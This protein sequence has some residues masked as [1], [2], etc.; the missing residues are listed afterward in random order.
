MDRGSSSPLLAWTLVPVT[1]A[2]VLSALSLPHQPYT[3]LVLQGD[4][5][6]AVIAGSPAERAGLAPGDRLVPPAGQPGFTRSPL[7]YAAVGEPL[8]ALRERGGRLTAVRV[9]PVRAAGR[10][11]AHDGGPARGGLAASCS[12][13]AGCGASGATGSRA[14]SSC[15]AS[16]SPGCWPRCR[17]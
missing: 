16:P 17:A 11:A 9:L 7:A 14:P 2:L 4:R 12:S 15:S 13:A 10:R 5:V 8:D 1:A 6:A 3:G